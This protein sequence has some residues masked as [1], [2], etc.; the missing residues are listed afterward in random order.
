MALAGLPIDLLDQTLA[1][2]DNDNGNAAQ[3]FAAQLQNL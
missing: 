3:W 2:M 1:Q